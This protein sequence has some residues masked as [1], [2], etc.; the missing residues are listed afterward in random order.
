MSKRPDHS[1]EG[2]RPSSRSSDADSAY[3]R[4]KTSSERS[5]QSRRHLVSLAIIAVIIIGLVIYFLA[6]G[7]ID[8]RNNDGSAAATPSPAA[9]SS[10]VAGEPRT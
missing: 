2:Y 5:P 4:P 10:Q 8:S 7:L 9:R 1:D 3:W 6:P